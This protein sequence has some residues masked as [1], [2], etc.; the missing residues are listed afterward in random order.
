MNGVTLN[1]LLLPKNKSIPLNHMDTIELGA[2]SKFLYAFRIL[3]FEAACEPSA[4]RLRMPLS[5]HNI[6]SL[7]ESPAAF[8]NWVKSKKSLELTLAQESDTL[9]LKLERQK[10]LNE[11]L[12]RERKKLEE[13]T[14]NF[15]KELESK[16]AQEKI[17][18]ED[19]VA[20]GDLEKNE[21]QKEKENLERRMACALEK[22]QV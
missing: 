20:R 2:G 14:A 16:F 5:N 18:L 3:S 10:S 12:I 17:E 6:P 1:H 21:L 8:K 11:E 19:K 7:K 4:K 15:K 22:F 9:D 13:K